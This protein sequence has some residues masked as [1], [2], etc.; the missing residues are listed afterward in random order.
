[1]RDAIVDPYAQ[2]AECFRL[3]HSHA[4]RWLIVMTPCFV[5]DRHDRGSVCARYLITAGAIASGLALV[6]RMERHVAL[7]MRVGGGIFENLS[8]VP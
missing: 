1:V 4:V 6:L 2:G 7:V 3:P 8:P 5:C